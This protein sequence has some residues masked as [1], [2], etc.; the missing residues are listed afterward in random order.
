MHWHCK[1]DNHLLWALCSQCSANNCKIITIKNKIKPSSA[2][3]EIFIYKQATYKC[4]RRKAQHPRLSQS[5]SHCT[6]LHGSWSD[7]HQCS[8][9]HFTIL[10][11]KFC[12]VLFNFFLFKNQ[13]TR[14]YPQ[15]IIYKFTFFCVLCRDRLAMQRQKCSLLWGDSAHCWTTL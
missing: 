4:N 8:K 14:F 13:D 12:F 9:A 6:R 10:Q 3:A 2:S 5:G 1:L 15:V 7:L 11:K